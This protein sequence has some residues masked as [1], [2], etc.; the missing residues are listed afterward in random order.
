[1]SVSNSVDP[2]E[3]D[4]AYSI[5]KTIH[6]NHSRHI[7]SLFLIT[8]LLTS[9]SMFAPL[10]VSAAGETLSITQTP[11]TLIMDSTSSAQTV[12]VTLTR[13]NDWPS[14]NAVPVHIG[15]SA[16]FGV[17]F[18]ADGGDLQSAVTTA[19]SNIDV[20]VNF[21]NQ[22]DTTATFNLHVMTAAVPFGTFKI[23]VDAVNINT[24]GDTIEAKPPAINL[25]VGDSSTPVL[26]LDP[27][28]GQPG[29][30][31]FNINGFNFESGDTPYLV[32]TDPIT[33]KQI[34]QYLGVHL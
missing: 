33:V 32:L 19:S 34:L 25:I 8:I 11:G 17:G 18:T 12:V 5:L 29:A 22:A 2:D 3:F 28:D 9:V 15:T 7:A 4:Q 14:L 20:T 23:F 1:M 24:G 16:P 30:T 27:P 26:S 6:K 21:D 31:N 13:S 10:P